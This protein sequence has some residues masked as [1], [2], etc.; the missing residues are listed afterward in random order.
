[1]F[2]ATRQSHDD[3][4]A[5][6]ASTRDRDLQRANGM[7]RIILRGRSVVEVYQ[8]FS[9][10]MRCMCQGPGA[11]FPV[12]IGIFGKGNASLPAGLIEQIEAGARGLKL[13]EHWGATPSAIDCCLSVAD[14]MDVQVPIQIR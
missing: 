3:V 4:S 8:R 14:D 12:N 10:R 5:R 13:H 9:T 7:G 2:E 1:M 11:A 6:P